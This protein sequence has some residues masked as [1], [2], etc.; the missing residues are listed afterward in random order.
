MPCLVALG[1]LTLSLFDIQSFYLVTGPEAR[2]C[3]GPQP[4]TNCGKRYESDADISYLERVAKFSRGH[5]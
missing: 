3:D 4:Q 2:S 5:S 1:A